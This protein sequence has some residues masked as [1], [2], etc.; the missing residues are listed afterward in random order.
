MK[1]NNFYSKL[2]P[3]CLGVIMSIN[4][5]G[6][7]IASINTSMQ[8]DS[9]EFPANVVFMKEK[10]DGSLFV[11]YE[12]TNKKDCGVDG[13]NKDCFG[14][15][16]IN[17]DNSVQLSKYW[18]DGSLQFQDYISDKSSA[19]MDNNGNVYVSLFPSKQILKLTSPAV[20]PVTVF[21]APLEIQP[22]A[23]SKVTKTNQVKD[24]IFNK[25]FSRMYVALN[26]ADVT[27]DVVTSNMM[28]IAAVDLSEAD[29]PGLLWLE[30]GRK[31]D[32]VL[33]NP[34]SNE[35]IYQG[36][37]AQYTDPAVGYRLSATSGKHLSDMNPRFTGAQFVQATENAGNVAYGLN[38][39][40][41][42]VT[43]IKL[44]EQVD[45]EQGVTSELWTREANGCDNDSS[46]WEKTI[47]LN[48]IDDFVYAGYS[49][50]I[51][52]FERDGGDKIIDI[53][54]PIG[55]FF[56]DVK[57]G[58]ATKKAYRMFT[59]GSEYG[60]LEFDSTG[61]TKEYKAFEEIRDFVIYGNH[62]Y[63]GEGKKVV[64]HK[65]ESSTI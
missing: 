51:T 50:V 2:T 56:G 58:K 20:G 31:A 32:S 54:P 11:G 46:S 41:C 12:S 48:S 45:A 10:P 62:L 52:V 13:V 26:T 63:L 34:L 61:Q 40:K 23:D 42:T 5:G 8:P 35:L 18:L 4:F 60:V 33:L 9:I 55:K 28:G 44:L 37:K 14:F 27:E 3:V 38:I 29:T 39:K 53:L 65:L 36:Y 30:T 59:D 25:D 19:K 17:K 49:N 24:F 43:K 7:A 15:G 1:N 57:F 16:V 21:N 64:K 47:S 22:S 6:T